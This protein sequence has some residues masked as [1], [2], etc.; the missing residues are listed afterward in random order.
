VQGW[1]SLAEAWTAHMRADRD[2]YFAFN[3]GRFLELVPPP[4]RATLLE[5]GG[6]F[7]F[8][9]L[10]PLATAGRFESREA[11]ARFAVSDDYFELRRVEDTIE[12]DGHLITFPYQARPLDAYF[13]ALEAAALLVEIVREPPRPWSRVPLFLHVRAVKP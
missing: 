11:A 9:M 4:G 12:R 7:C 10:H 2:P 6:R 8:N 13:R 5:P 1:E 3:A